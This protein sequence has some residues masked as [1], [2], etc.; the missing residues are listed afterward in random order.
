MK[1]PKCNDQFIFAIYAE[2]KKGLIGQLLVLFNRRDYT[3]HSLNVSRTDISDLVL[4]TLE[5]EVPA[6]A[7][8]SFTERLKKIVEVYAIGTYT[9]SLRKTGFYRLS[10]AA[11]NSKLWMLLGKYGATMSSIGEDSVVIS[12][13]GSDSDLA[14]LYC[15]LEGPHLIGFCK[16]GLI[17]EESLMAFGELEEALNQFGTI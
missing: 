7:L 14:E 16:S 5:A 9:Q 15:L 3:V 13:T 1:K 12:K 4:V 11:L 2:D 17:V 10:I 8:G 6:G